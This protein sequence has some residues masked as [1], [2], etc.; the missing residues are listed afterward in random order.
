MEVVGVIL[1][2]PNIEVESFSDGIVVS[3]TAG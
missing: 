3:L 2:V 1:E